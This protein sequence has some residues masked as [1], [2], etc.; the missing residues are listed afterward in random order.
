L[1][2]ASDPSW[3]AREVVA[4]AQ[5][6]GLQPGSIVQEAPQPVGPFT[7]LVVN[8]Q[9]MA[10]YHQLG[11]FVDA[12]ERSERFIHVERLHIERVREDETATIQLTLSTMV[13]P[14]VVTGP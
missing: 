12:V 3:L 9:L 7:R 6:A 11:E 4:L 8:L 10:S 1:P 2:Q 13:L 5:A 14:P